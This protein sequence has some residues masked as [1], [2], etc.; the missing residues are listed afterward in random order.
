[1][2]YDPVDKDIFNKVL[3]HDRDYINNNRAIFNRINS[4]LR[5]AINHKD[6][7]ENTK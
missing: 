6:I 7:S 2:N 5:P 3:S 1:M 4:Y